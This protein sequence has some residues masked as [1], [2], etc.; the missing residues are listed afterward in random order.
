MLGFLHTSP[1]H[2]APFERIARELGGS[3]G[4][5]HAVRE[6]LLAR[7]LTEGDVS[8]EVRESTQRE[9]RQLVE[10]GASVVLCTCSTLGSAAE[11]TP[12]L[13]AARV[14]RVDR[15]MAEQA[16]AL[17][18]RVLIVAAVPTALSTARTL[19]AEAARGTTYF[20]ADLLCEA[21]WKLFSAG[22]HAG[23]GA[24]IAQRVEEQAEPGD[25]VLLAQASMAGAAPLVRRRDI[26]VLTSPHT[27]VRAALSLISPR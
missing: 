14:L 13:G 9:V 6:D 4:L 17:R 15:P 22:D 12:H 25:V 2:V 20:S 27:G 7:A 26:Q 8:P 18:H 24:A 23:Y 3:V 16:I 21:A 5:L 11:S 19:L 1:V 10:Q